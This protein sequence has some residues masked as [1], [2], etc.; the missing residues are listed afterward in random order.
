M[1][2]NKL[3]AFG[4]DIEHT[5]LKPIAIGAVF[6]TLNFES[7]EITIL[8]EKQIHIKVEKEDFSKRCWD[9]YWN[10]EHV[11][12]KDGVEVK[13]KPQLEQLEIFQKNTLDEKEALISFHDFYKSCVDIY[14]DFEFV[15][16]NA[17]FDCGIIEERM[18][19]VLNLDSALNYR[20]EKY[21]CIVDTSSFKRGLMSDRDVFESSNYNFSSLTGT[22]FEGIAKNCPYPH[23]H[24]PLNDAKSIVW[25][26]L[27]IKSMLYEKQKFSKR[28]I[29]EIY[30][31]IPEDL[32]EDIKIIG[33]HNN[34][35]HADDALACAMLTL[36]KKYR[37]SIVVRSRDPKILEKCD[38]LVDVGGV[39]DKD[40]DRFDHHQKSFNGTFPNQK[41]RLSSA[42]LVYLNYGKEMISAFTKYDDEIELLFNR[43]YETFMIEI[44]GIDNGVNPS[45]GGKFNYMISTGLASQ[46]SELNPE[47]GD[48]CGQ[49][50]EAIRLTLKTFRQK[51]LRLKNLWLPTRNYVN[52]AIKNRFNVHESGKILIMNNCQFDDHLMEIEK[53]LDIVGQILFVVQPE[54]DNK[55]YRVYTVRAKQG[56]FDH[57]K[58]L[59]GKG[60]VNDELDSFL[61]LKGCTFVHVSGF[62]GGANTKETALKMAILSLSD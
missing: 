54:K 44:D 2:N 20:G 45:E 57:R 39:Y 23:D 48:Y 47:D 58:G 37:R 40:N 35:F 49:F 50:Q 60:L 17:S 26:Y 22:E 10:K 27:K 6:M 52:G 59:K 5:G 43:L 61:G 51:L 53:E 12:V 18:R 41:I 34:R 3:Y 14:D 42:G 46:V 31:T 36:T 11:I 28:L 21:R 30:E 9:D 55:S 19:S 8:K 29:P 7:G 38:C 32:T 4:I 1:L 16:D 24:I 56:F 62:T 25:K 13:T 33:T 15:S